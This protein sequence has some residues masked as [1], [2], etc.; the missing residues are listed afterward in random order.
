[1]GAP[2]ATALAS[3]AAIAGAMLEREACRVGAALQGDDLDVARRA[4]ARLVG[5]RTDMLDATEVTRAVIETVAEN[6]VDAVTATLFWATVGGSPGALVHR[7]VN[8]MDA[9]V[10]HRTDRHERFGWAS[11]RLDDAMNWLPARL[12][13]AAVVIAAPSRA[14][15][16]WRTVRR[17]AGKHPSPNGGVVEAAFAASLGV[18]LGGTNVYEGVAE[19]RGELGDGR[20]PVAHDVGRA[21]ALAR[22]VTLVFAVGGIVAE[23]GVRRARGASLGR[24]R[25]RD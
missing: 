12:T 16:V 3:G 25:R 19:D 20:A 22:R 17:D 4:V 6:T 8:T 5:R 14:T 10:G 11:A 7:A 9:M 23:R 15:D 13:V 21:V 2:V 1:A 24:S 18:R